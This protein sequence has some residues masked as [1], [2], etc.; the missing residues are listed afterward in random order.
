[1]QS[2]KYWRSSLVK[3]ASTDVRTKEVLDWKGIHLFHFWVSSCS[4][5]TRIFLNL[6]QAD[7]TSHVVSL[8]QQEN[9][10][11]WYLG[12]NPRGLVPCLVIDGEV[13]I[14]SND[15]IE[16][17]DQRL[18]GIKLIPE[19]AKG[20]VHE[21]L[22]HENDL[23]F[24]L[25]TLTFRYFLSDGHSPISQEI[26]DR[27]SE[28]ESDIR[29]GKPD[30]LKAKEIQ[31]WETVLKDP[32]GDEVAAKSAEV[33]RIELNQLNETLKASP[34]L[35]GNDL[36]VLDVAWY[37]YANRLRACGYPLEKLHSNVAEWI[38]KLDQRDEFS[39]EVAPP[40]PLVESSMA[41]HA[42]L[43]EQGS[44]L[45]DLLGVGKA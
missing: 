3:L 36:S 5:K 28:D 16:L 34:Y 9:F 37:S 38:E 40:P 6:K 4:Q 42:K 20:K 12:I 32:I 39:R 15:I 30:P 7:W 44:S 27:F 22:R 24:D 26:L 21:L 23:H 43:A 18:E 25:R 45:S 1:M 17:L 41:I 19:A 10:D 11:P 31:Y 33:F 29:S 35:L 2:F 13:H 8:P 14:E